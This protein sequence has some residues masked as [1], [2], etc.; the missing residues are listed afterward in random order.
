MKDSSKNRI[1]KNT[2][3][4]A[5]GSIGSKGML[6][7]LYIYVARILGPSDYG[8]YFTSF[9]YVSLLA[10]F[11]RL[12]F[13]MTAI[14]EG[15][16]NIE[17]I[18]I[19]LSKFL[20]LRM[21]YSLSILVIGIAMA[22]YLKYDTTVLKIIIILSPLLII[23]GAIPSGAMEHFNNYFRI[24]EKMKY[25]TIIQILRSALMLIFT[26]VFIFMN[27]LNIYF[28]TLV[29]IISSLIALFLQLFFVNKIF[30]N[31]LIFSIDWYFFKSLLRPIL[32]FGLVSILYYLSFKIDIQIINF[33]L[34][35]ENVG[36]YVAGWQVNNIGLVFISS[37]SLSLFPNSS[38][39]ISQVSY[40][41]KMGLLLI[42]T[43]ILFSVFILIFNVFSKELVLLIFGTEFLKTAE[44]LN[45]LLWF[46]PLRVLQLWGSQIL[47]CGDYLV[48]RIFV[49]LIPMIIN[50]ILNFL[51]IPKYG[52]ISAAY[53]SVI[54]S[55]ILLLLTTS[56]GIYISKYKL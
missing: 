53:S 30:G 10:V 38:R 33:L 36:L 21:I 32:L 37:L 50:I 29:A 44:I 16:K 11:A 2:G 3:Y 17:N 24:I 22:I 13:D 8:I 9:E 12:G 7:V 48:L 28:L 6:M 26:S 25:V 54:T 19:F 1:L 15:S 31:Y 55:L 14:R 51:L 47:E 27:S 34:D 18:N 45:I 52:I 5:I 40:R 23:G 56:S 49:Y 42:G 46:I 41:K 39:R 4:L 35:E 20:F 43:S